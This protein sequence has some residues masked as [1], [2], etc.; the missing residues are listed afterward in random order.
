MQRIPWLGWLQ[1]KSRMATLIGIKREVG[2][3][4]MEASWKLEIGCEIKLNK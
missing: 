3:W 2:Y 1:Y 4:M